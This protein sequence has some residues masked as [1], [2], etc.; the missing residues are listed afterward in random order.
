[1]TKPRKRDLAERL[2]NN[3]QIPDEEKF[4][5]MLEFMK[6]PIFALKKLNQVLE[7]QQLQLPIVPED[8]VR[9]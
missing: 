6:L 2:A 7:A 3:C 9:R 1:M 8:E 4:N 5:Y